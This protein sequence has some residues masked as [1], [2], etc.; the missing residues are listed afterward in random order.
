L[1][2]IWTQSSNLTGYFLFTRSLKLKSN[3]RG[4]I[5]DS[6][7]RI[8]S[9]DSTAS[10][11]SKRIYAHRG[12]WSANVL[13][14]SEASFEIARKSGFSVETDV[15]QLEGRAVISHDPPNSPITLELADLADFA[16]TFAIN[17]K[18]DGLQRHINDLRTWVVNTDSFVFDGSIPEMY[19][20]RMLGIPHA[21]RLSEFEKELPWK[22]Q[23]IW[24][25]SFTEDWWISD[26]SMYHLIEDSKVIVVSP[27]LHGRDPR[28][29][30]D[31]L[32]KKQSDGNTNF[33]ICT[34][35]PSEFLAW[36]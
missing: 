26:D 1:I 4:K 16:T 34:D 20:F 7:A 29:V 21:L 17:L 13:Q 14:N 9:V 11:I 28:F 3:C 27:E 18:E 31:Y 36:S 35:R 22:S 6:K 23:A 12:C 8:S 15:R 10:A 19:R 33:S 2:V 24:L 30:W 5:E 32:A 25:D